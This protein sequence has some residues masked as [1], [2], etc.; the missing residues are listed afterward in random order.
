MNLLDNIYGV[1]FQPNKTFPELSN[2]EFLTGSF[3]IVLL[4]SILT[5]LAKAVH[6][7]ISGGT[8][9]LLILLSIGSYFFT[10]IFSSLLLTFTADFLGGTGKISD[11]MIGVSYAML[12]MIFLA[13]LEVLTNSDGGIYPILVLGIFIWSIVLTV[14][15][16]KYAHRFHTT[17]AILS[18]VSIFFLTFFAIVGISIL[19]GLATIL[20]ISML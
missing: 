20:A 10:W 1:L 5:G 7:G 8:L 4:V 9:A 19:T 13:P 16:L 18:L 14:L 11:T 12:P 3:F 15:A 6:L 17:Q 2:R